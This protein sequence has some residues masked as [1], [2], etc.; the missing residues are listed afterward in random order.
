MSS[1]N[2]RDLLFKFKE[3]LFIDAERPKTG[4]E[5]LSEVA[6]K[7]GIFL[8]QLLVSKKKNTCTQQTLWGA[9]FSVLLSDIDLNNI[10]VNKLWSWEDGRETK[11]RAG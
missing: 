8:A 5:S 9:M 2:E 6:L 11:Y 4:A 1:T 10:S 7:V 3:D